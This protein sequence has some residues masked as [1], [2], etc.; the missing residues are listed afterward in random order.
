LRLRGIAKFRA[1][2]G[3][4]KDG[5]HASITTYTADEMNLI[6]ASGDLGV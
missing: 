2:I 3:D 1:I 4:W 5:C 6:G